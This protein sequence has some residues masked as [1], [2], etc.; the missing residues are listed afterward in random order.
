MQRHR[1]WRMLVIVQRAHEHM[2]RARMHTCCASRCLPILHITYALGLHRDARA[3]LYSTCT[4]VY[5]VSALRLYWIRLQRCLRMIH[6]HAVN[7]SVRACLICATSYATLV[8]NECSLYLSI[9]SYASRQAHG[10]F[11]LG[12]S[13]H[14]CMLSKFLLNLS[15]E[16]SQLVDVWASL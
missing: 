5:A 4:R 7:V 1:C 12:L 10:L 2:L 14:I 8:L 11:S 16:R 9:G 6:L 3:V 15:L 13:V